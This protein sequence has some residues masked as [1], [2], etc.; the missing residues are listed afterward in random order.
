VPASPSRPTGS[1]SSFRLLPS[2]AASRPEPVAPAVSEP[3][4]GYPGTIHVRDAGL[5]SADDEAVWTYAAEHGYVI[6][7]KDADF[8][9][10]SFV[11][12]HP[13]KV[14]WIR[15]GNCSTSEI[16]EILRVRQADLL[17]FERDEHGAFLALG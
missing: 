6:V 10:R 2:E 12:G 11:L 16:E 1:A 15:Q 7:S 5:E 3:R 17:A 14:V 8:H 13:P 4:R 9:H